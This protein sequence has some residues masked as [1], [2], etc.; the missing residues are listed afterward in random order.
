MEWSLCAVALSFSLTINNISQFT[1]SHVLPSHKTTRLLREVSP[2][3][4]ISQLLLFAIRT[5]SCIPQSCFRSICIHVEYIPS[6]SW[7]RNDV[8]SPRSTNVINVFH[9]GLRLRVVQAMFCHHPR[10][11]IRMDLVF[12]A[13]TRHSQFGPLFP[14]LSQK[15][16]KKKIV[17]HTRIQQVD[18][19]A[20]FVLEE[21]LGLRCWTMIV[22]N[23]C[24]GRHIQISGHSD[25]G[26]VL[27]NL[28][29]LQ[30]HQFLLRPSFETQTNLALWSLHESQNRL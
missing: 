24:R 22:G 19:H 8:G 27:H 12:G 25:F 9:I 20:D 5:S 14:S 1:L 21:T 23:L 16:F 18:D 17:F 6:K 26:L 4:V 11:P 13:R 15:I 28:V 10:V 29:A 2:T 30:W 7:S 3:Q